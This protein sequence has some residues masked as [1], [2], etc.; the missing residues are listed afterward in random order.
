[1]RVKI[2]LNEVQREHAIR[3]MTLRGIPIPDAFEGPVFE[4][5][6]VVVEG[7]NF[8][9][10]V[11]KDGTKYSYPFNSIARVATYEV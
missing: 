5:A 2:T 11:N 3:T 6:E 8:V 10:V 7:Q 9:T 1:M 4:N